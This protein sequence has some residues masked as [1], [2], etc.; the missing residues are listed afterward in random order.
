MD[1]FIITATLHL[2]QLRETFHCA[3]REGEPIVMSSSFFRGGDDGETK[4]WG[5][6]LLRDVFQGPHAQ[7]HA[8]LR[9]PIWVCGSSTVNKSGLLNDKTMNWDVFL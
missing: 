2:Q 7:H 5:L 6:R 4:K 1:E 3:E 8:A 9:V